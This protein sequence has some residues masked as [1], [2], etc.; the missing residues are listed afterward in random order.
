MLKPGV[1]RSNSQKHVYIC[2]RGPP[3]PENKNF[4]L[5]SL[6]LSQRSPTEGLF[7]Q[8]LSVSRRKGSQ[9]GQTER[10]DHKDPAGDC[11]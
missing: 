2:T 5:H 3:I 6:L 4:K 9:T 11:T 7:D 10:H 8:F 1:F